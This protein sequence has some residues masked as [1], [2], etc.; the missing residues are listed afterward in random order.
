MIDMSFLD[1]YFKPDYNKSE[2]DIARDFYLP[3]M[4]MPLCMIEFLVIL[5]AQYML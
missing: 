1:F 3:A 4:K 2:D 5:V